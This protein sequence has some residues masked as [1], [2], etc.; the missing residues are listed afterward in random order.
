MEGCKYCC[1]DTEKELFKIKAGNLWG[2]NI[3]ITGMV[4]SY[5]GK[6]SICQW[7]GNDA[8]GGEVKINYCPMCGRKL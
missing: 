4:F 2:N 5:D 3:N 8:Y 6:L 1:E 7:F